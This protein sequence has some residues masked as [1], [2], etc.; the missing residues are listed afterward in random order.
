MTRIKG[1][2]WLIGGMWA[3]LIL[4]G[5]ASLA[6]G[7]EQSVVQPASVVTDLTP[8][9]K[10]AFKDTTILYLQARVAM[11]EALIAN[12]LGVIIQQ[13]AESTLQVFR[14]EFARLQKL[15]NADKCSL[16]IDAKWECSK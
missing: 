4:L 15:H 2:N 11:L 3:I 16:T 9:E 5:I 8:A 10:I 14:I 7:Q 12:K 13:E 1:V 6:R